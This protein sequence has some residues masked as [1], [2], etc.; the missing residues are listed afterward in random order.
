MFEKFGEFDSAEEINRAAAA[1]LAEGDTQAVLTIAKENGI[2]PEDA[3]DYIDGVVDTLTT[4]LLAATGKIDLEAKDLSI[5][6]VLSDWKDLLLDACMDNIELQFAV[7][8]K[9]KRVA[10]CMASLIKFAYENKVQVSDKITSITKVNQ[11]GSSVPIRSP[12]YMGIPTR[13]QV[14]QLIR[15][16]YLGDKQ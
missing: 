14:Q 6:G 16:Y 9:G 11:N 12:L 2:D 5:A 10:E 15:A 8:K 13:A 3:Q 1:Q 4:P 7:R